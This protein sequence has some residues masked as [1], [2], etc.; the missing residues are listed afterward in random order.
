MPT[1]IRS[2][3]TL[4]RTAPSS[5]SKTIL[6][7][8]FGFVFL[9]VTT[10]WGTLY[11]KISQEREAE[12][13]RTY[14][15]LSNL[16]KAF[17]EHIVSVI[18]TTD[19]D[20]LLLKSIYEKQGHQGLNTVKQGII[21][22]IKI[23]EMALF[24]GS[25]QAIYTTL[26]PRPTAEPLNI[27]NRPYFTVHQNQSA[28][29]LY[30]SPP[31]NEDLTGKAGIPFSRSLNHPDG[32][33]AGVVVTWVE[34]AY[35]SD[36]YQKFDLGN[37]GLINFVSLDGLAYAR[38]VNNNAEFGQ[39]LRQTKPYQKIMARSLS[40]NE[41][42]V[43]PIDNV[44]RFVHYQKLPQYPF[45]LSVG[46]SQ[47]EALYAFH[48]RETMYYLWASIV[49]AGVIAFGILLILLLSQ[50]HHYD[51]EKQESLYA[52]RTAEAANQAKSAFLA[53]ISHE[54]RTPINGIIGISEQMIEQPMSP[55][56]NQYATIIRQSAEALLQIINDILDVTKMESGRFSI[57]TAPFDLRNLLQEVIELLIPKAKEKSIS[58][59]TQINPEIAPVIVG[60][61]LRVRQVLLNLLGNAVKF[62]DQGSVTIAVT[63]QPGGEHSEWIHI[64][65]QDTGIGIDTGDQAHLFRPYVQASN[66]AGHKYGGTGL[67]LAIS[68]DLV[69]RM[70]GQ[71][72]LQSQKGQ[73]STFW[74]TLPYQPFHSTVEP[75][76]TVAPGPTGET[77]P[78]TSNSGNVA[79]LQAAQAME[80]PVL[81]VEDNTVNKLITVMQLK[82]L[83][84]TQIDTAM[85][86]HAALEAA[87]TKP[88]GL[89]LMDVMLPD[90]TGDKITQKIRESEQSLNRH[91]PI[92]ALTAQAMDDARERCFDAGMDGYVIKPIHFAQ[93]RDAIVEV[94]AKNL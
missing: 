37:N 83:G 67:G 62:T 72:G 39:D 25:G 20:L 2:A 93:L 76:D 21:T 80:L 61:A 77:G 44:P 5:L 82:K 94:L 58:L 54:I 4:L 32:S 69:E 65:V 50:Q 74:F 55:I 73:G 22:P 52:I 29:S 6:S 26:P 10:L 70:G 19:Q 24:D 53:H 75:G 42:T 34:S 13:Q 23:K 79:S 11:F 51:R 40:G 1:S 85:N 3:L 12:I 48:Q 78:D 14:T 57:V 7:V 17:E 9:I 49:T 16:S 89:I 68:K 41:E 28:Q 84:F 15:E 86:G 43:S 88:Y 30:I 64:A 36:F 47:S 35:I 90:M 71:V 45:Y 27:A 8:I 63:L 91:T 31:L 59:H 56:L 92:L 81:L 60:D 38:R 18:N 33:F 66:H 87:N 46:M